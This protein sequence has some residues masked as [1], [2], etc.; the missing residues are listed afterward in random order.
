M[1]SN[2]TLQNGKVVTVDLCVKHLESYTQDSFFVMEYETKH[3][4]INTRKY[5]MYAQ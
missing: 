2:I 5:T 1:R 4:L 3:L